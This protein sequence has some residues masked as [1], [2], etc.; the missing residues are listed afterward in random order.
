MIVKIVLKKLNCF[1]RNT[2]AKTA[3]LRSFISKYVWLLCSNLH[4]EKGFIMQKVLFSAYIFVF[5]YYIVSHA[6]IEHTINIYNDVVAN[7][8]ETNESIEQFEKTLVEQQH[9]WK[10][11]GYKALWFTLPTK[12]AH[13]IS[14]L[15]KH[16]LEVHHASSSEIVMIGDIKKDGKNTLPQA[17]M[18]RLSAMGLVIDENNNVLVIKELYLPELGYKLPSGW[19]NPGEHIGECARR[20][21]KEETGIESEFIGIIALRHHALRAGSQSVGVL[22]FGCLMKPTSHEIQIQES[23]ISEACWM[24][25]DTFRAIARDTSAQ[26]LDAYETGVILK[27]KDITQKNP[28]MLYTPYKTD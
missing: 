21:I 22:N 24:P 11:A 1:I 27:A 19:A 2:I 12:Y 3:L 28:L 20:E 26:L 6:S 8:V 18:Q 25:Y 23:E 9:I 5:S 4:S 16:E 7:Y 17:S 15:L 10:N 13:Y 14:V